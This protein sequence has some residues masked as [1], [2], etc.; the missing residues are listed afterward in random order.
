S[1]LLGVVINNVPQ[2]RLN[3]VRDEV[4]A[5]FGKAGIAVLGVVPEDRVLATLSI[6]ELA[7]CVNGKILNNEEKGADLVEN[8]MLGAMV[9]D[10]G[11]EYFGRKG[12]KAA[13]IRSD[14][15]DMQ[16]AALE[17][18]T[19]CLVITGTAKEP[20]YNVRQK[21]ENKG[22]PTIITE[23]DTITVIKDIEECLSRNRFS[24]EKKFSRLAEVM[25]QNLDMAAVN[26]GLG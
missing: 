17:T 11:L 18:S 13:V 25:R 12:N 10:S 8:V 4:A 3:Q 7:E 5:Q 1:N 24:Q 23:S 2:S 16:L 9:V 6:A 21:A 22:I 20:V 14:R 19:R 15:P 26:K